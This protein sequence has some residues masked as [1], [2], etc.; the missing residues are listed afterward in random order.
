[1]AGLAFLA[2]ALAFGLCVGS[3]L[4]V[5]VHRLPRMLMREARGEARATLADNAYAEVDTLPEPYDLAR[6]RSHC[7]HCGRTVR[8]LENI[9]LLSFLWLRGR[10]AGCARSISWRYPLVELATG[11]LAVLVALRFG[12]SSAGLLVL[13]CMALLVALAAIDLDT[14][15]LPDTLTY[16]LLWLGLVANSFAT[17]V[18]LPDAVWG[19][20]AGYLSLWS[21]YW[22]FKLLTGKEGM[23]YGDFKLLAALGAWVGWQNLPA[24]VIVSSLSGALIGIA[25]IAS[26]RHERGKP[27]PFGP[28]LAIAGMIVLLYGDAVRAWYLDVMV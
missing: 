17:F 28:F 20:I 6:P 3:F 23:G 27:L 11:V 24:I 14:F 13:V 5:V 2:G 26:G 16:A 15:Y 12:Q 4:N 18:P 19:A 10:C 9:P 25:L 8:A 1:M 21:I 22:L 7:P